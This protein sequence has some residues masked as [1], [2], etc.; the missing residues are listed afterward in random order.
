M[1]LWTRP[2]HMGLGFLQ[3]PVQGPGAEPGP[4]QQPTL[5]G[6]QLE[7]T[8]RTP[9]QQ[10][11]ITPSVQPDSGLGE[12]CSSLGEHGEQVPRGADG[13]AAPL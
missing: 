6:S 5:Q 13:L 1:H 10:E 4:Q 3:P 11:R 9:P 12:R 7:G 2:A 8:G